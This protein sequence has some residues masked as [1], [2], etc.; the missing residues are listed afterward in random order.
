MY[1]KRMYAHYKGDKRIEIELSKDYYNG[2]SEIFFLRDTDTK[3]IKQLRIDALN[4]TD[5]DFTT[6][7]IDDAIIDLSH[8]YE[9]V[10]QYGLATTLTYTHLVE[11]KNFDEY[12]YYDG[13]DLGSNFDGVYT[14][15]NVWAPTALEVM[16]SIS[17]P[18]T[19]KEVA[20]K[21]QRDD[22]GVFR[23]KL[24]QNFEKFSYVYLIRHED[25]FVRTL[26]PYALSSSANSLSN[27]IVNSS[28]IKGSLYPK[29][30]KPLQSKTDAIIYEA[31]VRDFS[32]DE[33]LPTSYPGKFLGMAQSKLK[34]KEGNLVGLD[35]LVDL[36][37]THVQLLPIFDYETVDENDE[38]FFYNWGY[39]PVQYGIPEGSYVTDPNDGYKRI[40]ELRKLI[41]TLHG[42]GIRV[43]MD[44]VY[45]HVYDIYSYAY[46]KIVPG[47]FLRKKD[48]GT[49]CN[50]SWCGNDVNTSALMVRRYI[51]DMCERFQD[52]YGIDGL[53]FDLM[54][55]I[56]IDTIKQIYKVCHQK[57][58]SF[59]M[60]GEGWN[61]D[62]NLPMEKR[63][64]Q[65]NNALIPEIG[66]FNDQFR[67]ILKGGS[68]EDNLNTT[69]YFTDNF[70]NIT[71]AGE[72]MLNTSRY[73]NVSQ[74]I[75]YFECHDNATLA[76]KISKSNFSED[77]ET[78]CKRQLMLN[79]CLLL[80]QGVPFIHAGQE[81][82]ISK[83]GLSNTYNS[84]DT[85]NSID[86]TRVDDYQKDI[87]VIK[88]IIKLR[89]EN[90]A[91]R[92][93]TT[94][95]VLEHVKFDILNS[96]VIRYETNQDNGEYS[97]F[98]VYYNPSNGSYPIE[99]MN[100]YEVIYQIGDNR[101]NLDS[102]SLKIFGKKR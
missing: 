56:D 16:V 67:D 93:K 2:N 42:H 80:S 22:K 76:D 52:L 46:E 33:S 90:E 43:V 61:M 94:K 27:I 96:T 89:K 8:I 77:F 15:F 44:V 48:D 87:Q 40:E 14:T 60:Y 71:L 86:W 68:S 99:D 47:Y 41:K 39:N 69:G 83:Q 4:K 26:D 63:S 62:T 102:I 58:K 85:I 79:I 3:T 25:E 74:S 23:T 45:N 10:D 9:V 49:L 88:D 55:I 29:E 100:E 57:D 7:F 35:Y 24:K 13:N 21:M 6:Y 81:F 72:C 1:S 12:F 65:E 32:M 91:F 95:D 50:G 36:G 53:R 66:F 31:S 73:S 11:L 30:L 34:S 64:I 98:V 84:P 54:G 75:N 28:K 70:S 17:D 78:R 18:K 92:Y 19:H 51:V 97:S 20:S 59:I 38:G 101:H 37:I 5:Y 82:Y